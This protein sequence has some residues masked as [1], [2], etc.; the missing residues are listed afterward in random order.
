MANYVIG[1]IQGCYDEF[2]RLLKKISFNESRDILWLCGDLV[3]RGP[4]SL[5]VMR[6]VSNLKKIHL[7]LGNHDLHLLAVN[8][9]PGLLKSADTFSDILNAAEGAALCQWLRQQAFLHHDPEL[10]Y[11]MVHAGLAPQWD[12]SLAQQ[13][14]HELEAVLRG[15][16]YRNFL[17]NM[18]GDEP[19]AW[20]AAL[21]GMPRL[22]FI[23]N[24][25]TRLRFCDEAGNID[26]IYKGPL[27]KQP[28]GLLPWFKVKGRL[29]QPQRVLFGH[30]AALEG[31]VHEPS[32]YAMDTGCVWGGD[33]SAMCLETG[34]IYQEGCQR[35]A[36]Y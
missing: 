27:G 36:T 11:L 16:E 9:Q 23:A 12:V 10:N 20:S 4:H 6:F 22:R 24:C 30:W 33:L 18:Y 2:R 13:C 34:K 19:R 7:V 21:L 32:V 8:E 17:K 1:D 25:F 14:A 31:I 28:G 29:T 15:A 3:N 26:L 5:D 35:Y